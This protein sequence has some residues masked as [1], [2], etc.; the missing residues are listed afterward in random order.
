[1]CPWQARHFR[2]RVAVVAAFAW[3]AGTQHCLLGLMKDPRDTSGS[4]SHCP[5]HSKASGGR[6]SGSMLAC[7]R[8]LLSSGAA[9]AKVKFNLLFGLQPIAFDE[10]VPLS[11]RC[12]ARR[13]VPR[14]PEF[15]NFSKSFSR[16]TQESHCFVTNN[17]IHG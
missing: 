5:E 1:M 2:A 16:K 6:D 11:R 13:C 15:L 12:N 4:T 8:G 14:L 7:C 9:H 10:L 17:S 3:F